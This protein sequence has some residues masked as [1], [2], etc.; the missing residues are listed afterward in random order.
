M[1]WGLKS[2]YSKTPEASGDI[3]YYKI[4]FH[5]SVTGSDPVTK[6]LFVLKDGDKSSS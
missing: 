6:L 5:F 3:S 2:Y 4:E 1:F